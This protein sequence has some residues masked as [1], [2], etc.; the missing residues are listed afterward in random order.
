MENNQRGNGGGGGGG[1]S[2]GPQTSLPILTFLMTGASAM[3]Y[4]QWGKMTPRQARNNFVFTETNFYNLGHYQSLFLAPLSY[5]NGMF[6][7]A[8]LPGFFYSAMLVERFCGP[9]GLAAAYLLNC[10][11]SAATTVAAHRQIGY[12]KVQQRGRLSNTNGNMTLFLMSLFAAMAPSYKIFQ[13]VY[14][15]V[16]F[17]F[18]PVSYCVLFFMDHS[19]VNPNQNANVV[20]IKAQNYNETHI[21]CMILGAALGV[22]FRKRLSKQLFR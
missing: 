20:H 4:Y 16:P 17:Y 19:P 18:I 13:S 1:S 9:S 6:F 12:H 22:L 10:C 14:F 5:E 7:A 15:S 2:R 8:N 3:I 21:T 11:V